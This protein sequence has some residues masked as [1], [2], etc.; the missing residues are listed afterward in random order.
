MKLFISFLFGLLA[1][2]GTGIVISIGMVATGSAM[3][4]TPDMQLPP[5]VPAVAVVA[6]TVFTFLVGFWRARRQSERRVAHGFAVALGAAALHVASSLGAGQS[7]GMV[8]V[9]ADLLKLA[10]G[11]GAGALAK[12]RAPA[13]G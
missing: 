6:G 5:W 12:R 11:A 13:A 8:H 1:E 3:R 4:P 7:L 2:I 10:A 9:I